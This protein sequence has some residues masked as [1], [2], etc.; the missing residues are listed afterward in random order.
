MFYKILSPKKSLSRFTFTAEL[1]KQQY[2]LEIYNVSHLPSSSKTKIT[3]HRTSYS[4]EQL[5]KW[6]GITS[7]QTPLQ[8]RAK[9]LLLTFSVCLGFCFCGMCS[10]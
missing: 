4:F 6:A 10:F 5:V 7:L 8:Y 9:S 2:K 3:E 1:H